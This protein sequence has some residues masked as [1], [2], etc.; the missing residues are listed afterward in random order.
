MTDIVVLELEDRVG[1]VAALLAGGDGSAE[2]R[3]LAFEQTDP[4]GKFFNR[5]RLDV[6]A[7]F[8]SLGFF[9]LVIIEHGDPPLVGAMSVERFQEKCAALFWFGNATDETVPKPQ[10]RKTP[11]ADVVTHTNVRHHRATARRPR[12]HAAGTGADARGQTWRRADQG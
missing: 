7:D 8:V 3:D 6:H 2:P 5:H 4:V 9:H 1:V 10:M 11:V 12:S